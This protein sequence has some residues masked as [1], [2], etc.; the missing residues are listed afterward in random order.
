MADSKQGVTV[1]GPTI[2]IRGKIRAAEDLVIKCRMEA[3]ISS[4]KQ[5]NVDRDGIDE[6]VAF[7]TDGR[8]AVCHADESRC[9]P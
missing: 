2:V 1:I 6:L 3:E 4:T 7:A 5:V 9:D 8:I